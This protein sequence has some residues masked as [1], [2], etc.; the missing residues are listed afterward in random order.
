MPDLKSNPQREAARLKEEMDLE[1]GVDVVLECTGIESSVQTGIQASGPGVVV[2]QIGLGKPDLTLP[3]LNMCEK[4]TV[5]KTAWR[6]APGD[7]EVSL[8]LL[9]SGR[10]SV[11]PLI[12]T[13][14]PFENAPEAWEMTKNGQG[15]KNLIQ[16]VPDD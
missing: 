12:S 1:E 13:I 8:S 6:N 7:Y 10:I 11:K 3:I 4:E 16:G 14:V 2:I 9:S 15:I 5:F